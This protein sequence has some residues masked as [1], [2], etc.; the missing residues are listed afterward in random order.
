MCAMIY[1][2]IKDG[3]ETAYVSGMRANRSCAEGAR[4]PRAHPIPVYS[5]SADSKLTMDK[6]LIQKRIDRFYRRI[7]YSY[8]IIITQYYSH[9]IWSRRYVNRFNDFHYCTHDTYVVINKLKTTREIITL[10]N[11]RYYIYIYIYSIE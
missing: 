11:A 4:L 10:R 6:L 1:D 7:N 8:V 2:V 5:F 9:N 3:V